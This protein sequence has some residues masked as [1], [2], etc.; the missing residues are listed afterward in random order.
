MDAMRQFQQAR[1][2]R[3]AVAEL[4]EELPLMRVS[5]QLT[6]LAEAMIEAVLLL[7]TRPLEKRYG[8]PTCRVDGELCHPGVGIVAYGKLGGL[9]LGYGSDLDLVFVHESAGEQQQTGA[10]KPIDNG[11][12]YA[13]LAQKM[14]SF[15][16]TLTP[17]GVLN[18][19]DL[20]L[21]PNGQSGV[22]VTG[23]D[24]FD[25]YQHSDAWT[26][27]HQALVRARMV[28]GSTAVRR[29]FA[30]IRRNVLCQPREHA[31]LQHSVADMRQ[32]MRDNLGSQ[33]ADT[34]DLKQ[35]AGGVAD[36]EFMVQYLVLAHAAGH[37]S[38]VEH[39]DNV[40]V[41]EAAEHCGVLSADD[42]AV[43]ASHYVTLRAMIH[44][45]AL[46][47]QSARVAPEPALEALRK[48]VIGLW[49]QLLPSQTRP[50][51]PETS[52]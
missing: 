45:Q 47:K 38:L 51:S 15:M 34:I 23:L 21:R 39:T 26:W 44:R 4:D 31:E 41:L 13:H 32:R 7:V 50:D 29:R 35:D 49:Q 6:W 43:L 22:L 5:D 1:E 40:R 11:L 3:I 28:V 25:H 46:Q 12:Y 37:P 33:S 18:D 24:A 16:T 9:E 42:R 14:V 20:R 30:A 2:L 52:M 8:A 27:E 36:I 19:I 48:A 17:A 10:A